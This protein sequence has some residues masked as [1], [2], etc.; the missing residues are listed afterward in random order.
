MPLPP[1]GKIGLIE[2]INLSIL[3]PMQANSNALIIIKLKKELE[4]K[5]YVYFEPAWQNDVLRLLLF[6][7]ENNDFEDVAIVPIKT[8]KALINPLVL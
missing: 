6:L 8:L 4:D 2:L 7:K 3:L 5:N 1:R